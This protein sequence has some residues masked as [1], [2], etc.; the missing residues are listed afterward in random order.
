MYVPS[1][2]ALCLGH[3]TIK[4]ITMNTQPSRLLSLPEHHYSTVAVQPLHATSLLA[5]NEA[6]AAELGLPAAAALS[7][8]E[9]LSLAGSLE[10]PPQAPIATVYSGHQFGVWAGQLGD[11]RAMLLGEITA[12]DGQQWELQLKG[13]GITPYS[14]RADGRAVLRSSIREYL[15]SEYM[16][17]LGIPTTRALALAASPDLVYREQA[18]TAAVVTRV[19]PSFLRFGHFEH[20]YH[21]GLHTDIQLLADLLLEQHYPECLQADNPYLAMFAAISQ[22]SAE[23][24][25]AWQSVGFCHG[26][27][28][29]DNMSA[30]GLTIDYGPFGFLDAFDP[31]HICN[32]SD[33]QGRYAYHA[34]PA[35]V[36]WNLSCL[37]S[38]FLPLATEDELVSVLN[39]YVVQYKQAYLERMRAKLGLM[40][41]VNEDQVLIDGLLKAMAAQR[42][43]YSLC[44]RHLSQVSRDGDDI[45][46]ELAALWPL[47]DAGLQQWITLYRERLQAESLSDAERAT[48]MN[49]VNPKYVLRQYLLQDA[50]A[51]AE[52][53]DASGITELAQVMSHPY[54][55]QVEYQSYAALPPDWAAG[56]CVSCSS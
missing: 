48:A 54:D 38:C 24:V 17:A 56:I 44:L 25:A 41:P 34:Q 3:T 43:D 9:R 5:Y 50:I 20:W 1:V 31:H 33:T 6:L 16:H 13:A 10:N 52:Q 19:A 46:A 35:I 23:L 36:Q 26:V 29:T 15:C 7:E 12:P 30:L 49:A 8:D 55:E 2:C 51:K 32:H 39:D 22:R 11:G 37:A 21:R 47:P 45:P 18:E 14:R 4:P 42:V 28:N 40:R 27:L 53:G